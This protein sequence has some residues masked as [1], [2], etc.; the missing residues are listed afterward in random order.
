[1]PLL[2]MSQFTT[3]IGNCDRHCPGQFMA[4]KMLVLSVL[5]QNG[6]RRILFS[7]PDRVIIAQRNANA[8]IQ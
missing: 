8:K 6:F 1:M 7:S 5:R 2:G 3:N 4:L